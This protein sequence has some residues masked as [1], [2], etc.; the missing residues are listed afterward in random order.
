M[1]DSSMETIEYEVPEITNDE[2]RQDLEED[3]RMT[4]EEID[5]FFEELEM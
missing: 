2:L 3:G 1:E 4:P 5:E